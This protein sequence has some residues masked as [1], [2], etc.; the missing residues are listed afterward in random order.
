M[1]RALLLACAM[2][3][4]AGCRDETVVVPP[5]LSSPAL[6]CPPAPPADGTFECD[7]TSIPF[8]TYPAE[9]ETCLC[10]QGGDGRFTLSCGGELQPDGG[11][12]TGTRSLTSL[13][14]SH[15]R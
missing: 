13:P 11:L 1:M 15:P 7:V 4:L 9:S 12:P 14:R 6:Y 2:L 5:D 8:C 3:A 10:T